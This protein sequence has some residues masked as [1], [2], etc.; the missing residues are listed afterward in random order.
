MSQIYPEIAGRE[1]QQRGL[2][3]WDE[4]LNGDDPQL[5][6]YA[7][8]GAGKTRFSLAAIKHAADRDAYD[9]VV[10]VAPTEPLWQQWR[11]EARDVGIFLHHYSSD[12]LRQS[13]LEGDI[14]TNGI[15]TTYA[16]MAMISEVFEH[17]CHQ[18]RVLV[19]FDEIHH[20]CDK[21][22]WGA[23]TEIAFNYA[24]RRIV[25]SGTP[26]RSDGERIPFIMEPK[27]DGTWA[28]VTPDASFSY[29]DAVNEKVCRVITFPRINANIT[30]EDDEGVWSGTLDDTN[31]DPKFIRRLYRAALDVEQCDF[32]RHILEQAWETLE[33]IRKTEQSDA[34]M[35]V[36]AKDQTHA[37]QLQDLMHA[38]S[39]V[40][41]P[42]VMSDNPD[43]KDVIERFK[44]S[45]QPVIVS[46]KMFA[47]GVD[48]PRIRVIVFMSRE[49]TEMWFR[50]IVGRAVR[51]QNEPHITGAQWS[52]MFIPKLPDLEAMALRVEEDLE[53]IVKPGG[54][55]G[56]PPR[57][58]EPPK[59]GPTP[60]PPPPPTFI[61]HGASDIE[62][63]GFITMGEAISA[64]AEETAN[65]LRKMDPRLARF[66]NELLAAY[67]T[68]LSKNPDLGSRFE[69][70]HTDGE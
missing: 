17:W 16:Q 66:P 70:V 23:Q 47:E 27:S 57:G 53:H 18:L 44:K 6:V 51:Y 15:I 38:I 20:C 62:R 69:G 5:F 10:V 13:V 54:G 2:K 29:R 19:V 68:I 49:Q 39:K 34:A 48:A 12:Q 24:K 26:F 3:V 35:L 40:R 63:Q 32:P 55:I 46:V 45:K 65:N 64:D 67:A 56:R 4:K 52:H 43:S 42:A 22:T 36:I 25:L 7:C 21:R 60:P 61:V 33:E 59:D 58:P 30:F 8:P 28:V 41:V 9:L 37:K 31:L 1:W 11:D 14:H 50:Q